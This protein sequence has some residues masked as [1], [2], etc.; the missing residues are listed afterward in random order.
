MSPRQ[1]I[2]VD[3]YL[4]DLNATKA[5]LRA[6]YSEKTAKEQG[7]RLLSNVIVRAAINSR[8][9]DREKRTEITADYVLNIIVDTIERCRQNRPVLDRKGEPVLIQ[10]PGGNLVPAYV[11][12]SAGVLKG[13]ELLGKHLKLFS[14]RIEIEVNEKPKSLGDF[15]GNVID[16]EA[17]ADT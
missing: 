10:G 6:G 17:S 8:M 14:D 13:A 9:I 7:A 3:E 1:K 12:D 15:Y 11:F 5:A 2:F 4:V 16:G